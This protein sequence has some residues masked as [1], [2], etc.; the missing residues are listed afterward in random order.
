[1]KEKEKDEKKKEEKIGQIIKRV[2]ESKRFTHTEFADM[3]C[4]SRSNVYGIYDRDTIDSG[5]L[6]RISEALNHNFFDEL[7]NR[8]NMKLGNGLSEMQPRYVHR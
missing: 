2:V 4:V 1:M 7:S 6:A 5:L 3:I 8:V